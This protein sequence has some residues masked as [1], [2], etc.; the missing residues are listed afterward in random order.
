MKK[1]H[2]ISLIFLLAVSVIVILIG[3]QIPY[4]IKSMAK[5][6]PVRQWILYRGANGDILTH[7]RD[8]FRGKNN[9]YKL[10]SFERGESMLLELTNKCKNGEVIKEGD[11][12]GII[13]SNKK[14]EKLVQLNGELDILSAMLNAGMSG[15]KKT[16]IKEAEKRIELA[17][18]EY[19]RQLRIVERAEKLFSKELIAE[20]DFQSSVDELSILEKSIMVK[21][22]ELESS[23][24]G[25]KDEEIRLLREKISAVNN[26]I[27]FLNKELHSN[28][29]IL[30]PFSGR[31]EKNISGDTLLMLSDFDLGI[32]IIPIAIEDACFLEEGKK[33]EFNLSNNSEQIS[34]IVQ[35]KKP[36]MEI[37]NGKQCIMV[38]ATVHNL[39]IDFI[40]GIITKAEI[41]CGEIPFTE[42]IERT[43]L[44]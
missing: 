39:S 12:L 11:T 5:V 9:S 34:G 19:D 36:T 41:N 6:L 43:I 38:L 1:Y 15:E 13:V 35:L 3:I 16:E 21:Q 32:A 8:N 22:A 28:N 44:N 27:T 37:I 33:V 17:K 30:A 4:K 18:S 25:V 23:L 31:I 40:S 29:S 20:E 24:S 26:E 10:T 2:K 14:Q 7:S 42:F